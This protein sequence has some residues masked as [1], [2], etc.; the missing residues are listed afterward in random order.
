MQKPPDNQGAR[1]LN[2]CRACFSKNV[3][4]IL[5]LGFSPIANS[6]PDILSHCTEPI[7]PLVLSV[8][9]DCNLGQIAEFE[10]PHDIFS[11]YPYLSSTSSFWL[12]HASSF[13]NEVVHKYPALKQGY[14]LEIA[15][16][17]GYLLK[18]FQDQ[19]IEVL[20]VD[21]A[22]NVALIAKGKGIPTIPKFFGV[23]LATEILKKF[24][25]PSLIVANNVAAHV[26]DM[27]DFFGGVAK[28]CGPTT[29]V[30]IEN[31]SLGFLLENNYYDTIYHEHFSYLSVEP[32]QKLSKFLGMEL[33]D[34]ETLDTHGGSLRYWI[35]KSGFHQIN[36]SV[37]IVRDD[38]LKRGVGNRKKAE[39]FELQSKASMGE[40]ATWVNAQPEKSIVGYGAAAKTVT[41]FFAAR[42][43]ED[44][45]SMI[46]DANGLK[47]NHRLP[48]T[49]LPILSPEVL[50]NSSGAKVLVFPWNL[51]NEIVENIRRINPE[52]E[53]WIPNPLR[54]VNP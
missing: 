36:P 51:E 12:Q 53:I 19:G 2:Y 18:Y 24:G 5:D 50:R 20:G 34:V 48:G 31:P 3:V 1:G 46:I 30:S 21:P 26:P 10:S 29:I 27:A 16:N 37:G 49:K 25:A 7:Y 23:S 28:L 44:R 13:V 11:E 32:I 45:F 17:D 4:R 52:V 9:E 39:E 6:L 14:V 33:F 15:S 8:C 40:L 42:L 38:E 22:E 47:Q 54:R 35:G 41:T 43:S